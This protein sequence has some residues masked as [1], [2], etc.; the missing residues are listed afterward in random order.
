MLAILPVTVFAQSGTI[1]RGDTSPGGGI[2]A[3]QTGSF[4][5]ICPGSS[6][7]LDFS[8]NASGDYSIIA[9]GGA[10]ATVRF[11]RPGVFKIRATFGNCAEKVI[12]WTIGPAPV[13]LPSN[14]QT[15][16]FSGIEQVFLV[17]PGYV[18]PVNW[19]TNNNILLMINLEGRLNQENISERRRPLL[20]QRQNLNTQRRQHIR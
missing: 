7:D 4:V 13:G 17:I 15:L 19:Y 9:D 14:T 11:N 2:C 10:S 1:D 8:L 16:T 3:G 18:Q 6:A 20:H 12:E 5:A